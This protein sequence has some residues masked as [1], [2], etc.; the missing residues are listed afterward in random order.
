MV[1]GEPELHHITIHLNLLVPYSS[2]SVYTSFEDS[3]TKFPQLVQHSLPY[4]IQI[5]K[6]LTPTLLHLVTMSLN[7]FSFP[8]RVQSL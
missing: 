5:V 8:D 7:S 4:Q 6:A 3:S 1:K 2:F